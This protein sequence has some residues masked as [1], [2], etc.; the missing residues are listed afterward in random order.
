M[1]IFLFFTTPCYAGQNII[2]VIGDSLSA[3]H[4]IEVEQGWVSLLQIRLDQKYNNGLKWKIINASVSGET[5]AGG[6]ARLPSLLEKYN[7]DLCIIELGANNGLRGQSISLMRDQLTSMIKIC[8]QSGTTLL[9]GLKLPPNYGKKYTNKFNSSFS[10]I[11]NKQNIEYVPFI[12]NGIAL[13]ND[14]MQAD[15]L[16]PNAKAQPI[17]LENIWPTLYE[18]LEQI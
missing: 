18:L 11:A 6:L 17:I 1:V 5:T 7:P 13:N 2:L 10:I 16:H 12:L 3:A 9:L 15:G 14:L 8:N 4:G